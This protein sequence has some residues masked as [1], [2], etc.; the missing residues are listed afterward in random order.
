MLP[1]PLSKIRPGH[2][3]SQT[4]RGLLL[5]LMACC[6]VC[7]PARGVRAQEDASPAI[8]SLTDRIELMRFTD[9]V[10]A[11]LKLNLEYDPAAL[12]G[13]VSIRTEQGLSDAELWQLFN[14]VL[15]T[16]SLTT[17]LSPA[18]GTYR[19]V[20]ISDAPVVAP[21]APQGLTP[22]TTTPT[23]GPRTD[24]RRISSTLADWPRAG[25]TNPNDR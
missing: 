2:T 3:A 5:V 20:R 12:T 11:R 16:R 22:S 7:G 18:Q 24:R 23:S 1:L 25:C 15:A 9:L 14:G 6:L 21:V 13:E 10:A 4:T 17:V 8:T 19:I